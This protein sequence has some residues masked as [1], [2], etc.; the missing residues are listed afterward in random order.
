MSSR[1][2]KREARKEILILGESLPEIPRLALAAVSVPLLDH[3]RQKPIGE[4]AGMA[5]G[6]SQKAT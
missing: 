5:A 3:H 6:S 1:K 4:S 2:F